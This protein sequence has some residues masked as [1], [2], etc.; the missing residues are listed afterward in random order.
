PHLPSKE[1]KILDRILVKLQKKRDRNFKRM[2]QFLKGSDYKAIKQT[3]RVWIKNPQSNPTANL[4]IGLSLPDLLLPVLSQTLLH[5]GWLATPDRSLETVQSKATKSKEMKSKATKS[6]GAKSPTKDS[7]VSASE[8][9]QNEISLD[10]LN[11]WLD[12][13]GIVL[14]DL[15]K[16]MKQLRYQADFFAPHYDATYAKTIQDFKTIQDL[17]GTLQDYWVLG[18]IFAKVQGKTWQESLPSLTAQ[19][20]RDRWTIWQQWEPLRQRYLTEDTRTELRQMML[21]P[22]R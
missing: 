8:I 21:S 9:G 3:F 1:Q 6:K 16:Q 17:L 2:V 22:T 14:H 7:T 10:V 19:I 12:H 15:R 5:P 11:N 20:H 4:K 18:Q 13:D